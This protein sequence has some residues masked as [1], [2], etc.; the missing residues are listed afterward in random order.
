MHDILMSLLS[1]TDRAYIGHATHYSSSTRVPISLGTLSASSAARITQPCPP[2]SITWSRGV[3]SQELRQV[4]SGN[5]SGVSISATIQRLR[6]CSG[7]RSAIATTGACVIFSSMWRLAPVKKATL[8]AP[9]CC[10]SSLNTSV[11][12]YKMQSM[13]DWQTC[14]LEILLPRWLRVELRG[15]IWGWNN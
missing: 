14:H 4:I 6:T 9:G 3:A 8:E 7:A 10:T 11:A 1:P 5:S 12:A 15:R 13:L 2:L